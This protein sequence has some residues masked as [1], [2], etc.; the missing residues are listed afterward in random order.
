MDGPELPQRRNS[1]LFRKLVRDLRNRV[2]RDVTAD[3]Y[4]CGWRRALGRS[5]YALATD[6]ALS[7]RAFIAKA[8][9]SVHPC[10]A[11]QEPHTK[12]RGKDMKEQKPVPGVLPR[13]KFTDAR[14]Y[15][16]PR[17]AKKSQS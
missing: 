8:E 10:D 9:T 7:L 15:L 5:G 17:S 2:A 11:L 16:L 13:L 6:Q 1:M 12:D 3:P 4:T 14:I